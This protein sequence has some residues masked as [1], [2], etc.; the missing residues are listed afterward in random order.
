VNTSPTGGLVKAGPPT[1]DATT[2]PLPAVATRSA[3]AR[4][5]RASGLRELGQVQGSGLRQP[6]YLVRRGDGQV[7]QVSELLR[8]VVREVSAE[9]D[10]TQV[11][12]AVSEACGRELTVEG[13]RRLIAQKLAPMGLVEDLAVQERPAGAPG[14][15]RC[16]HCAF[17]APCCPRV[18][19]RH[20]PASWRRCCTQAWCSSRLS[21]QWLWTWCSSAPAA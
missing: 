10:D 12:A 15:I 18:P 3:D 8:L 5:C 9:R 13:L 19:Y 21:R 4:W 6:T 14:Q 2:E 17:A 7:L 1:D 20:A 16:S 11:A